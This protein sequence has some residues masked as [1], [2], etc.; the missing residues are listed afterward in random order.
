LG[1]GV[2]GE[3]ED[4]QLGARDHARE[5]SLQLGDERRGIVGVVERDALDFGAGDDGPKMWMG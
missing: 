5:L 1:G 4:E 3:V 2:G